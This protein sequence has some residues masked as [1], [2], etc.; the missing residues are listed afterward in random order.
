MHVEMTEDEYKDLAHRLLIELTE[1][2]IETRQRTDPIRAI[3]KR[4]RLDPWASL[5]IPTFSMMMPYYREILSLDNRHLWPEPP[6]SSHDHDRRSVELAEGR[7]LRRVPD[8]ARPLIGLPVDQQPAQLG[9][10][11]RGL[12]LDRRPRRAAGWT[13]FQVGGKKM[14]FAFV[15]ASPYTSGFIIGVNVGS[16]PVN[17]VSTYISSAICSGVSR[18]T[19]M[20]TQRLEGF[21]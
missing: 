19:T 16:A 20:T 11:Q 13:I 21:P 18:F 2:G 9:V 7:D 15:I 1:M 10:A 5:H 12:L 3:V 6:H 8:K 17:H 14:R 4:C